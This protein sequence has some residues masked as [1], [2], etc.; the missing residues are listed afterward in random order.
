MVDEAVAE[1]QKS[2]GL[3]G[4]DAVYVASLGRAYALAG[5]KSEAARI[6][7]ELEDLSTRSYVAPYWMASLCLGLDDREQAFRW[8]DKAY[9][10]RS[11]GLVWL[12]VDRRMDP[13]RSDPRFMALRQRVE[14]ASAIVPM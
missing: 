2:V 12:G 3:S 14:S 9:E 4:G 7:R 1:L 13:I 5:K 8:L 11:G 10:E 6:R